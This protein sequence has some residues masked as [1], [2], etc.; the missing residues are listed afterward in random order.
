MIVL[1]PRKSPIGAKLSVAERK[2]LNIEM[3]KAAGEWNRLNEIN[4]EACILWH[5]HENYGFGVKRL[6]EFYDSFNVEFD[7]LCKW[8]ESPQEEAGSIALTKLKQMGVDV[9]AWNKEAEV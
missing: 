8:Y 6:R 7:A 1:G 3:R 9:E 4:I 2:A 5:L